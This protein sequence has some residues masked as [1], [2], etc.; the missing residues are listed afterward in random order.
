MVFQRQEATEAAEKEEWMGLA[1][2]GEGRVAAR[3]AARAAAAMAAVVR[4][5]VV[6]LEATSGAGCLGF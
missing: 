3:V 1:M 4:V 6:R 5:A 2:Q